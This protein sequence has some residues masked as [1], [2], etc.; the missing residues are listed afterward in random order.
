MSGE[1]FTDLAMVWSFMLSG[2][3]SSRLKVLK[4][5]GCTN[6]VKVLFYRDWNLELR[7]L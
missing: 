5:Q 7:T 1:D 6:V 2:L 4:V 3:G